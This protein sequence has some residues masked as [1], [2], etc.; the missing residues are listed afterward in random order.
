MCTQESGSV[1]H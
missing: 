1:R